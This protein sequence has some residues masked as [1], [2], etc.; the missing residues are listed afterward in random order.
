MLD[1]ATQVFLRR[2]GRAF[3]QPSLPEYHCSSP[4]LVPS[5][6]QTYPTALF[7]DRQYPNQNVDSEH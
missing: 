1:N 3:R 4:L 5:F 6:S 7:L 2:V